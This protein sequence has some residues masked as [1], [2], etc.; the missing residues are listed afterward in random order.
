LHQLFLFEV[1]V[2][3]AS[4]NNTSGIFVF[5]GPSSYSQSIQSDVITP[6]FLKNLLNHI[7]IFKYDD[8]TN[9]TPD[10]INLLTKFLPLIE[11]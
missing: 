9:T 10:K 11:R 1:K 6:L 2:T 7:N 5:S 3:N 4:G 8:C